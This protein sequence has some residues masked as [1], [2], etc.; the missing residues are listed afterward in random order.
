MHAQ[1]R[2]RQGTFQTVKKLCFLTEFLLRLGGRSGLTRSTEQ[3]ALGRA[4]A[5]YS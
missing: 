3:A 5:I 1:K 2:P 4:H